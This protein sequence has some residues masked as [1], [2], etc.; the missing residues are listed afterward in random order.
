MTTKAALEVYLKK[1]AVRG[2]NRNTIKSYRYNLITF[3]RFYSGELEELSQ[4]DVDDYIIFIQGKYSPITYG[5]KVKA[6]K[7][8][9]TFNDIPIDIS[10]N[11]APDPEIYYLTKKQL[12]EIYDACL[13]KET[14]A[15]RRDYTIMRLM[16][17]TGMRI[18]ECLKLRLSDLNLAEL[19]VYISSAKNKK[20]RTVY[21]TTV[22]AREIRKY[23]DLRQQVSEKVVATTLFSSC[24]GQ[25]VSRRTITERIKN[26][27]EQAGITETR[28]SPH[29]FRHTFAKNYLTNGGDI[30]TLKDIL[31]H[32]RLDMVYRYSRLFSS[33]RQ[34][35]YT[36]IMQKYHKA[37]VK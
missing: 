34:E 37:K 3:Q 24:N 25:P 9:L 4:E 16:E 23:I 14:F 18:S 27:G 11:D 30:F 6:L 35:I 15:K 29:T 28:V 5:N 7:A 22:L 13:Y 8:F 2:L 31:G 12:K 32:S 10:I 21:L 20:T 1:A 19:T 36:K 17:E 33:Q 26:Y